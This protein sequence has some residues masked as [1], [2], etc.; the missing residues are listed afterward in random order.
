MTLLP[1]STQAPLSRRWLAALLLV[2]AATADLF[3]LERTRISVAATTDTHA[4][5]YP[6]DYFTNRSTQDGLAKIQTLILQARKADP[7]LIL[8]DCGDTIQGTPLGYHHMRYAPERPDPTILVMNHMGYVCMTVGN[9]EFNFGR[10]YLAKASSEARF[11]WLSANIVRKADQKPVF[12][13]YVIKVVKGVR[14]AILGITTPGIPYWENPDRIADLDFLDPIETA[15]RY[16]SILRSQEH[17]DIVVLAAHMGLEEDLS[18]AAQPPNLIPHESTCI[19]IAKTVPGIDLLFMGHTHRNTP[20]LIIGDTVISQAGRWADRLAQAEIFLERAA[21]EQPWRVIAR[22]AT[23]NAPTDKTEPDAAVLALVKTDHEETQAWLAHPI[24]TCSTTITGQAAREADSAILDLVHRVQLEAGHADISFAASFNPSSHINQGQV[25]V[26][27]I[28]SLYTYENTLAVVEITG[29]E[30]KAALEHSASYYLPF[31][32]GKTVAQLANPR[33]P[34]Y[35][36]DTAEG[37]EY[38]IDLHRPVG[39]RIRNLT[40]RGQPLDLDAKFRVAINSFRKNGGGGYGMFRDAKPVTNDSREIRDLILEWIETH[41]AVPA[42]PTNN[43][44]FVP[45]E[46]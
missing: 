32:P 25:T 21:P 9:H 34:G 30:V 40:R 14:V 18:T 15:A 28:Y 35:N 46:N 11:P 10:E 27:D 29:R 2:S 45:L 26:R 12:T 1:P 13:P 31:E 19:A 33:A 7:E 36:F 41:G 39:E 22:G 4:H 37:V 3:A 17:A 38:E 44:R 6:V 20:A 16:V 24:G 5:V 42:E 8:L 43:W 23:T